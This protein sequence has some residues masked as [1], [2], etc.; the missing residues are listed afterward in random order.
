LRLFLSAAHLF[1]V[2]VMREIYVRGIFQPLIDLMNRMG[3]Q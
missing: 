3:Q 1:L 2:V